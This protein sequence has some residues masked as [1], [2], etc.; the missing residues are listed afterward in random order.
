MGVTKMGND[1][2]ER[3]RT[4]SGI[5]LQVTLGVIIIFTISTVTSWVVYLRSVDTIVKNSKE[6]FITSQAE[7]ISSAFDYI[8]EFF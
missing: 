7:L 5:L 4:R 6:E 3:K 2:K 1:K 8:G